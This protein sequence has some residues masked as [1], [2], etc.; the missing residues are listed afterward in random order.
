MALLAHMMQKREH[1]A[2]LHKM[3]LGIKAQRKP[4]AIQAVSSDQVSADQQQDEDLH[5]PLGL[6]Q[7]GR[8]R[9][10]GQGHEDH[11]ATCAIP[12]QG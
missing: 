1:E 10:Y 11:G 12:H 4:M 7:L 9:S 2:A 8:R 3:N 6:G 5:C